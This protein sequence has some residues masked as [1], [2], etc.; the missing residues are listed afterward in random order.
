MLRKNIP[1]LIWFFDMEWVPDAVAA[2]RLFD[3]PDGTEEIEGIKRLWAE[4]GATDTKERPFLKYLL[5]RVVSV[6]FLSRRV[7]FRD[8]EEQITFTLYSLPKLP[9]DPAEAGEACI[10]ERFL[11]Y[12]GERRPQLVGYNSY[13]SDIQVLI[14]R[15]LVNEI[16]APMFCRRP[17][18]KWDPGDYFARWDNEDHFDLLRLFSNG[19]MKPKLNEL[20][21]LC[22]FPG[23]LDVDGDQVVDLWLQGN[24]TKI[25]E[26]NLIDTLNTYL[27]WLRVV[28]FCGKLKEEAY[29]LELE[30]FREFLETEAQKP[31]RQFVEK[32]LEKWEM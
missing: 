20:A 3:L 16:S 2:R 25:V 21:R 14:Q 10:I 23:K 5:S 11:H 24:L 27:V 13:E 26:Y 31:D 6:A 28:H 22:G 17:D 1:E 29:I 30:Q 19:A 9:V 12:I 15:G 4:Y 8:G 7:V 32:F 18:N